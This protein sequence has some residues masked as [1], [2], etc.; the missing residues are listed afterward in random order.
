M[1]EEGTWPHVR[2]LRILGINYGLGSN[3][4]RLIFNAEFF[5]PGKIQSLITNWS[6]IEHI[7]YRSDLDSFREGQLNTAGLT[8]TVSP[9]RA[10][11]TAC[12]I[13]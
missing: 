8:L 13:V 11:F 4:Q 6:E 7:P 10:Q 2:G 5:E 12:C 1:K 9:G 3:N